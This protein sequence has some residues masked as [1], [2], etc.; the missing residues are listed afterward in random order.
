MTKIMVDFESYALTPNTVVLS[1]GACTI[2]DTPKQFYCEFNIAEQRDRD[3]DV[4]TVDWWT[5]QGNPPINGSTSLSL[6]ISN[7]NQ[8]FADN[9]ITELWSNGTDFDIPILNNLCRRHHIHQAWKYNSVRDFRT[10][11]KLFYRIEPPINT[12]LPH[13]ALDDALYQSE[14]L[15]T[16]Y[17]SQGWEI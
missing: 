3:I 4:S 2:E 11:R 13:N 12:G 17:R 14:C 16:I 9:K 6:G 10:L 15:K 8:F 1:V 7:L 5:K